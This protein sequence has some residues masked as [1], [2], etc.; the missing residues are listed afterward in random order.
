M[1]ARLATPAAKV[2]MPVRRRVRN[3]E[4]A[5]ELEFQKGNPLND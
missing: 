5:R 1:A 4:P 2:D 3:W